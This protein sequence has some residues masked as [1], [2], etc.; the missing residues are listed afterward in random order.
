MSQY[1]ILL[2]EDN[3]DIS[4]LTKATLS[5]RGYNVL[6]AF[7]GRDGIELVKNNKVD[8]IILDVMMPDMDGYEVLKHLKEMGIAKN[9]PIAFMSAKTQADEVS[10]GLEM[11]AV[12]YFKKPF[13]P[14]TFLKEVEELLQQQ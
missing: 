1:T 12:K 11:G 8:L 3:E 2:M 14:M 5:F 6:T 9:V 10:K 4:L 13:D 7:N